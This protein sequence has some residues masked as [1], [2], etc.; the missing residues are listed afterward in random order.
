M[1]WDPRPR[2]WC[3]PGRD[4]RVQQPDR[5]SYECTRWIQPCRSRTGLSCRECD[6]MYRGRFGSG[7]GRERP[8]D[9]RHHVV[10]WDPRE[11]A[12]HSTLRL[13]LTGAQIL[14]LST[15]R[16]GVTNRIRPPI[17]LSK[18]GYVLLRTQQVAGHFI[19]HGPRNVAHVGIAV[20][21]RR[22]PEVRS[23]L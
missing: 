18:L 20:I 19:A 21:R 5:S 16:P 8:A 12:H 6:S 10:R 23:G 15:R 2:P 17:H 11:S 14:L 13:W 9:S 22:L 3:R 7:R 4:H 1:R